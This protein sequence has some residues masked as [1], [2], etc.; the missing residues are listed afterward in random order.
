MARKSF[1][2]PKLGKFN[3][4]SSTGF[5]FDAKELIDTHKE[6]YSHKYGC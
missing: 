4:L 1:A 3:K 2:D 5:N 6:A